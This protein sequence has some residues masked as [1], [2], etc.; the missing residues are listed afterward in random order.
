M[1][2]SLERE[3]PVRFW[4]CDG[5]RDGPWPILYFIRSILFEER[6]LNNNK[7]LVSNRN[8]VVYNVQ[9]DLIYYFVSVVLVLVCVTESA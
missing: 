5:A 6:I 1:V 9:C 3:G 8:R 7:V 2:R 4:E